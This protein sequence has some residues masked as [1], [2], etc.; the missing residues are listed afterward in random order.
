MPKNQNS[1]RRSL[2]LVAALAVTR[3]G[4]R[5]KPQSSA[6]ASSQGRINNTVRC[7]ALT[8]LAAIGGESSAAGL[9][10]IYR[11]ALRED[12]QYRAAGASNRADQESRPQ[13]LAL[14]RPDIRLNA[15]TSRTYQD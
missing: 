11:L 4:T 14:L 10:D 13:P 5:R 7:I 15:S 3:P 6:R 2:L 12:P 1:P 8:L 9:L